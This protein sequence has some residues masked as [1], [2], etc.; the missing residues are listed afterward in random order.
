MTPT[1]MTW[2]DVVVIDRIDFN[3]DRYEAQTFTYQTHEDALRSCEAA[4]E[5]GCHEAVLMFKR[6]RT[7][8]VIYK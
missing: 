5:R 3:G 8:E 7:I 1:T 6:T 4:R 2:W